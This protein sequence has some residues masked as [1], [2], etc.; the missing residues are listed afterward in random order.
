M[1]IHTRGNESETCESRRV[2]PDEWPTKHTQSG[3]YSYGWTDKPLDIK[4]DKTSSAHVS[5]AACPPL[6]MRSGKYTVRWKKAEFIIQNGA[7]MQLIPFLNKLQKLWSDGNKRTGWSRLTSSWTFCWAVTLEQNWAVCPREPWEPDLA[8]SDATLT[9]RKSQRTEGTG[10]ESRKQ[11]KCLSVLL[12]N[13]ILLLTCLQKMN[14]EHIWQTQHDAGVSLELCF[15][16]PDEC[17]LKI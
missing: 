5:E 3:H 6:L 11:Q 13:Q 14:Y 16:T 8:H 4:T 1:L 12:S 15:P 17:E 10:E 9:Y 2:R 7:V